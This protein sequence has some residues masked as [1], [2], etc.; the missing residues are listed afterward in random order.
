VVHTYIA[1]QAAL[2]AHCY[3][4]T[5][6]PMTFP[7]GTGPTTPDVYAHYWQ[8]GA[9]SQPHQWQEENR[10]SYMHPDYMRGKAG[11]YCNYFN[12]L[13]AALLA[14][15][16]DQESKPDDAY[17]YVRSGSP[18]A[19]GFRRKVGPSITWLTFP[20]DT[21]EVFAWAAESQ[22]V[23]L[24]TLRVRGVF[25]E[26]G[27]TNTDLHAPP[28]NYGLAPKF[29]SGQFL[30]SNAQRGDYWHS[31]LTDMGLIRQ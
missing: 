24:G 26:N 22:S 16:A 18:P 28:F 27:G 25:A 30:D 6:P 17:K 21:Y 14:W 8:N 7:A 15:Q 3:D 29:H 19:V 10:P 12:N 31:L 4:A 9:V 1:S 20:S 11:H 13:D 5:I 23:A 2:S